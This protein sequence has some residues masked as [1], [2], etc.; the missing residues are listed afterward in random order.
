MDARRS[1]DRLLVEEPPA[2]RLWRIDAKQRHG[3]RGSP[4]ADI[5]AAA[6]N[7]SISRPMAGQPARLAFQTIARDIDLHL[8]DLDARPVEDTLE[9]R[10]FSNRL[11]SRGRPDSRQTEPDCFASLRSGAT[12]VW[13]AGRDGSGLQ[14]V[15]SLGAVG[16]FIVDG[17]RTAQRIA[18][19]AAVAGNSD[20]Y[21][22]GADGGHLRRLTAEPSIEGVPSW[23][24]MGGGSISLHTRGSDSGYWRISP[25]GGEAID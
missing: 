18:F 6:R 22:V 4:I 21:L 19:E 1:G 9:S 3:G 10:P 15:T 2:S 8:M 13:V 7:L 14:Q 5:P 17:P 24:L 20:V 12:E 11:A 16:V 23:S 25:G